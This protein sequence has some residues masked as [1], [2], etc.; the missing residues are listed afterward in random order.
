M[1]TQYAYLRI[2]KLKKDIQIL[3]SFNLLY[4]MT[5]YAYLRNNKFKGDTFWHFKRQLTPKADTTEL[6]GCEDPQFP[7]GRQTAL[8]GSHTRQH[9]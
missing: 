1:M 8:T 5:Q 7:G 9:H 2:N 6:Q 4:M 3:F